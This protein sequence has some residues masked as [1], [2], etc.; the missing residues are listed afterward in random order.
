LALIHQATVNE[1][2]LLLSLLKLCDKSVLEKY[3]PL[4]LSKITDG[5]S[6]PF[7]VIFFK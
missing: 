4:A 7:K 2:E 3:I 5:L 1:K 6:R